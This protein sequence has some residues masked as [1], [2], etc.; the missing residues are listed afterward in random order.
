M[1]DAD[2]DIADAAQLTMEQAVSRRSGYTDQNDNGER[3]NKEP[4]RYLSQLMEHLR[5]RGPI[6]I[7]AL[8]SLVWLT[9]VLKHSGADEIGRVIGSV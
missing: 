9:N 8:F 6:F 2:A 7:R 5:P 1:H 3:I 4:R